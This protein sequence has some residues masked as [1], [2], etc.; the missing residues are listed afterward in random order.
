MTQLQ[1]KKRVGQSYIFSNSITYVIVFYLVD[2]PDG[3]KMT[4][5]IPKPDG[6]AKLLQGFQKA[7]GN[8]TLPKLDIDA[9]IEAFHNM[10]FFSPELRNTKTNRY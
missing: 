9:L 3:S 7:G 2:L 6:R 8:D 10:D 1:Y 5:Y 4:R